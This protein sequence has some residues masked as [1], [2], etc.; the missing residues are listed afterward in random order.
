M[1]LSGLRTNV[2]YRPLNE[3]A[4]RIRMTRRDLGHIVA[5]RSKLGRH[6]LTMLIAFTAFGSVGATKALSPKSVEILVVPSVYDTFLIQT[7]N[8]KVTFSDNHTEVWTDQGN[9]TAPRL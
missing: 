8:V 6:W 4:Y 5:S 1:S 3:R 9:A 2:T 7:G